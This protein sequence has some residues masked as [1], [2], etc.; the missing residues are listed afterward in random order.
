[1]TQQ[2]APAPAVSTTVATSAS[3]PLTTQI[4]VP[5]TATEGLPPAA[6]EGA[7]EHKPEGE[8]EASPPPAAEPTKLER[9]RQ[10]ADHAKRQSASRRRERERLQEERFARSHAEQQLQTERAERERLTAL[11]DEADHAPLDYLRKKGVTAD[12][13]VQ[14]G[15]N[16][17]TPEGKIAALEERLARE[18]ESRK[19]W[20]QKQMDAATTAQTR[21]AY[22]DFLTMAADKEKFPTISRLAK[23]RPTSVCRDGDEVVAAVYAKTKRYPSYEQVL[24]YLETT[25]KQALSDEPKSPGQS[26]GQAKDAPQAGLGA[27]SRTLSSKMAERASLPKSLDELTPEDQKAH[28]AEMLRKQSRG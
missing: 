11:L 18:A 26:N 4:E 10:A 22:D 14:E 5:V 28:L 21:K 16:A 13:L 15:I 8:Q 9:A 3:I 25:Y 7:T 27:G 24:A 2:A 17:T 19:A 12:K 23:V 20:E 1:M 6:G